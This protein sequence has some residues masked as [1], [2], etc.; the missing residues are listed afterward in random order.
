MGEID[1]KTRVCGL[2]ANPVEHTLSPI[3]HNTLADLLG[4]NL[5]YVP[6]KPEKTQVKD[7]VKGAYAL[8]ML[9]L[10]VSVPYKQDVIECLV[11]IDE[12]AEK[13]GAVNTL[14]RTDGGYKGYN[15]DYLGLFRAFQSEKISLKGQQVILL[16]A[17]GASKAVSYLCCKEGAK[18]VYLL[19]RTIEKA[20]EIASE[21]NQHFGRACIE[22][23]KLEEY[24]KIPY[25]KGE[26]LAIQTTSVGMFPH[27]EQVIIEE[28]KFYECLHTAFDIVYTP[29]QTTFMRLAKESGAKA[30]NGL[31]MLLYQGIIAY[32]LWNQIEVSEEIVNNVYKVMEKELENQ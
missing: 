3:L 9:G 22:P 13:I 7:A 1:G 10:N 11:E 16:G 26:Y 30:Y 27:M 32:E 12:G 29:A 31:K 4:Q 8:Q 18:K 15:T 17:G 6:F 24:Y 20:E 28:K 25:K 2:I 23:L 19:N 5:V 14:V 21:M